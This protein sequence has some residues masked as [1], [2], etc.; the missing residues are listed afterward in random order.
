MPSVYH[1][2]YRKGS[3]IYQCPYVIEE[4]DPRNCPHYL[5]EKFCYFVKIKGQKKLE[6]FLKL[7]KI[8]GENNKECPVS[9]NQFLSNERRKRSNRKPLFHFLE[10]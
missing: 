8:E 10:H 3:P 5:K 2:A 1:I 7:K 6:H 4:K 9:L